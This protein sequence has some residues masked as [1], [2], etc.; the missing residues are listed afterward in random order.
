M[1]Y[2]EVERGPDGGLDLLRD[3]RPVAVGLSDDD[4]VKRVLRRD[5]AAPSDLIELPAP[6]GGTRTE[7]VAEYV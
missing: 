3:G 5:K 7:V 1:S 6:G 4:D 2:W